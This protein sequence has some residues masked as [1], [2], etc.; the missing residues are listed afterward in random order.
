MV[1]KKIPPK[2]RIAD[3]QTFSKFQVLFQSF[4]QR[5]CYFVNEDVT[6][7]WYLFTPE[8]HIYPSHFGNYFGKSA[9][10]YRYMA[11]NFNRVR[12][13]KRPFLSRFGDYIDILVPFMDK[14]RFRGCLVS[15]PV[16]EKCLT[17]ESLRDQWKAWTGVEGSDLDRDFLQFTRAALDSPVLDSQGLEAYTR[18]ME[19]LVLW[20]AGTRDPEI[21]RELDRL[22]VDVLSRQLPHPYWVDWAIGRNKFFA[23]PAKGYTVPQW[24]KE[25]VGVSRVPT[26]VAALMPQKPGMGAGSLEIL[27]QARRFQHECY[28]AA[29]QWGEMACAPLG[30]YGALVL[31]SPTPPFSSVQARLE[32]R[33][34]IQEFGGALEGKL[35]MAVVAGIGS[36]MAQGS[37]LARSYHEA[38]ASLHSA[39]QSGKKAVF[40]DTSLPVE[41]EM[42]LPKI[43]GLVRDL[44]LA[45]AHSSLARLAAARENFIYQLL[46]TGYGPEITRASLQSA[47]TVL[48]DQFERRTGVGQSAARTLGSELMGRLDA[49][50][51]LPELTGAFKECIDTLALYQDNPKDASVT[52]RLKTLLADIQKEPQKPWRLSKLSQ[53]AGLSPPTFLKWFKKVSGQ[54]F[55]PYV[56]KA[57]LSKAEALLKEGNLKLERVAQ[58]CGF[59][60]ASTFSIIFRREFGTTPREYIRK[61]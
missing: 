23:M 46:Y 50:N 34:R 20:M 57:R 38:V 52:A 7:W 36:I 9:S 24:V 33:E 56:R 42:T 1:A 44:G 19:L 61:K 5:P 54:S 31:T 51:T 21:G 30:D 14:G 13:E 16:L 8:G 60:S 4:I 55:G 32:I 18:V 59:A 58:E 6:E 2:G 17:V 26:V 43:Q 11:S 37:Q 12:K 40:A 29:R 25:E 39:V 15:G 27:C 3:F 47:L 41:S 35:R 45:L 28:L 49:A 53:K 22:R 48:L 10:H